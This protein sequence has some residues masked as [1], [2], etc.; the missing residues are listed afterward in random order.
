MEGIG[1]GI[2]AYGVYEEMVRERKKREIPGWVQ[3]IKARIKETKN[4]V[5]NSVFVFNA[6]KD[7]KVIRFVK[8]KKRRKQK[9]ST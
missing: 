4:H 8:T 9:K 1:K 5:I 6:N 2:R 7:R 3:A